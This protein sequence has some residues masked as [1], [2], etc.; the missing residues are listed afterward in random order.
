MTTA[1]KTDLNL[2]AVE[3]ISGTCRERVNDMIDD[4]LDYVKLSGAAGKLTLAITITPDPKIPE[5]YSVSVIPS[6]A[7]KGTRAEGAAT[8]ERIGKQ[9]QLKIAG[10]E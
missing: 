10:M 2:A 8:L 3:L 6:L 9:I 5:A 1:A 4:L 7:V